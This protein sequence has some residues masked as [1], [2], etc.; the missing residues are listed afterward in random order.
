MAASTSGVRGRATAGRSWVCARMAVQQALHY[1]DREQ[2]GIR[3]RAP[4]RLAPQSR[5]LFEIVRVCCGKGAKQSAGAWAVLNVLGA[6][7][8]PMWGLATA[9][10]RVVAW[11]TSMSDSP[12]VRGRRRKTW[13]GAARQ[14]ASSCAGGR[15][16]ALGSLCRTGGHRR[17]LPSK[18]RRAA[19]CAG[20]RPVSLSGCVTGCVIR[21]RPAAASSWRRPGAD[22]GGPCGARAWITCSKARRSS[23]P[24]TS[25]RPLAG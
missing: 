2:P 1:C 5:C 9:V 8:D 13:P 19:D 4:L 23:P 20:A 21:K 11:A 22:R 10:R 25:Q 3:R 7:Q 14:P 18:L 17:L 16:Q 6:N 24:S 15:T 12:P